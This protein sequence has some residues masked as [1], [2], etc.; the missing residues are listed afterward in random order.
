ML[1]K[2]DR[3]LP[4]QGLSLLI[5]PSSFEI[6]ASHHMSHLAAFVLEQTKNRKKKYCHRLIALFS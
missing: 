4:C 3:I 2:S 5:L 1:E 6:G